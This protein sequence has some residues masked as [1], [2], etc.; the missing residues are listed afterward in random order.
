MA[1]RI[2]GVFFFAKFLAAGTVF[3]AVPAAKGKPATGQ[4]IDFN[5][6]IRPILSDNCFACHG[7]DDNKRKAKLRFD[8]KDDAFKPAKSGDLAIV[9]G[10]PAKSKMIERITSKDE[11]EKMPPP[12]SGKKLTPQQI[13]LLTRW[14]AQGAKWQS[15]WAFTKPERAPLPPI[16]DKRW[17]KN[18]IDYFVL[19]RLEKEGLKPSPEADK[20]T[21]IRRASF[22]LTGMPPTPDEV[23]AFLADKSTTAYEK[24]VDRLLTSPRYGENMARYWLDAARYADSHGYHIDS[25]RSIW[26]WREWVV[27]AFN[28]N[29]PFDEFTTEQLAGDLIPNATLSQKIASGYIRN[30]MSTGEG[31]AI[32]EEY[33][34]KYTFDRTETTSTIWLGL[35][36]TCCRCH[37]HKYD[38]I[39]HREYYQL[40]SFFNNLDESVMDDNK[41]NPSPFIQL[42]SSEQTN[43][44]AWLKKTFA[45]GQTKLDAP[46]PELDKAQRSWEANWHEK[47]ASGWTV[48]KPD[49]V[50]SSN[51]VVTMT[52]NLVATT[53]NIVAGVSPG[54]AG[55]NTA[56]P[57]A[58]TPSPGAAG[59]ASGNNSPSGRGEGGSSKSVASATVLTN[60]ATNTVVSRLTNR[61]DF[62]ILD[63]SSVLVQGANPEQDVHEITVKLQPGIFAALRLEA[64]PD[65]SLPKKSS[66]RA[67]NGVF[68]LSEIE[69]EVL[70]HPKKDETNNAPKKL[71]FTQALAD[72]AQDKMDV[73]RAIDG[74]ADTGWSPDPSGITEPHTALFL[75]AEPMKI[76]TNSELR[77]QLRYEASK[78]K[79]AIGRFRLAAAQNKELVQLL[80]PPKPEPWNLI[81]PFK[82]TGLTAGLTNVYPPEK[83]IDLKKSY[84][85]VREE[86]KWTA[87]P[88]FD[89]GKPHVLVQYLHG[90]PGVYYLYRTINVPVARKMELSVR[91]DDVFELFL[92][93]K[94]VATD[95]NE[96]PAIAPTKVTVD[97]AKGENKFLLKIVNHQGESAFTFKKDL[98][99]TESV[100]AEI[101]TMFATT[102]KFTDPQKNKLREYYRRAN[103]PDWKKLFEDVAR[104]REEDGAIEKAIPTTMVAKEADKPRDTFILVR[105]EYDKK[106]DKVTRGVPAILPPLPPGVPTN[107]FGL[108]KWLVD[109]SHPLTARVTVNRY[110]QQ[111]FGIGFVKTAEDFGVQG[112]NPSHPALLD[113]LATEFI[114]TGW[115]IKN[116]QKLIVTSA[117]YK[118]SSKFTPQ[119]LAKDPDN[120]LLARGPRFRLDAEVVR[121]TALSLSGLLVENYGGRSVRPWQPPGLWEAVSF[122]N[123]QKYVPEKGNAEYRRAMYTYWKRQSPPPNL[124]LFDAP[125]RETCT[126]RRLRTNTPLQALALLND[127]QFVEAARAFAQRM[128]V[129]GGK[130]AKARIAYGFRL[131][132]SRKPASGEIKIL[133][134]VLNKE[135]AD[136]Q[137]DK[138]AADKF[139]G[140]GDFKARSDLDKSEL[141]AWTTIASMILNLDETITKS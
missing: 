33:Q 21:L 141:A 13:E 85:G 25:E 105:G 97:L 140:V 43:R 39:Q 63:D 27:S 42:P 54:G 47:L 60:N 138:T 23:D 103:S 107:R 127:P 12:K 73:A 59:E 134:D 40:Y 129:E 82:T 98:D 30:N 53:T 15:H 35:T 38:P 74:K 31:G 79:R 96:A 68:R 58:A 41:P 99:D 77:V 34:C 32:T 69:A 57:E 4:P 5:R 93:G 17:P 46:I 76:P 131:A 14:I 95:T 16:K 132:T 88:D 101:A 123:S 112:E 111:Y 122:N 114:R 71:K 91:A 70:M 64:L 113:W 84:P 133:L 22:D 137:Q 116:L 83:E 51:F 94:I 124:M 6:D 2:S 45:D 80:N 72:S 7:P 3:A 1:F 75:L 117:T 19:N 24:V 121:D 118:Q 67:E 86:I 139:L 65:D 89:D 20:T 10:D 87:K 102:S 130:D 125:T 11:D 66:A 50:T 49:S 120:R 9:P 55:T 108:A 28:N 37:T 109:P 106:G 100:P 29:M 81:G 115:D 119:L 48:F 56:G 61:V 92:N 110:W 126:V 52:T 18:E 36:M 128:L 78:S 104:W 135:I 62:K 90:V 26:K 8:L 44:Q 136:Y